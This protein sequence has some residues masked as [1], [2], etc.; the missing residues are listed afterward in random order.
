MTR[1]DESR[2][3]VETGE[4]RPAGIRPPSARQFRIALSFLS[5]AAGGLS[6]GAIGVAWLSIRDTWALP[7]S[8]LGL[9]LLAMTAGFLTGSFVSGHLVT[10]LGMGNTLAFCSVLTALGLL[11]FA[12]APDW[13]ALI[14]IAILSGAGK[15][16]YGASLNIYFANHFDARL[17]NWLHASFGLG[18]ALSPF[19]VQLSSSLEHGWRVTW[20]GFALMQLAF[21]IAF[22]LT[23][24]GWHTSRRTP[25]KSAAPASLRATLRQPAVLLAMLFIFVLTGIESS[26]GNWSYTLFREARGVDGATAAA[27]VGLYWGSFTLGRLAFGMVADRFP[28]DASIRLLLGL[29]LL[30]GLLFSLRDSPVL[31]VAGLMLLAFAQAPVTPLLYA[32]S[33]ARLG[34]GLATHAIGF[35]MSAAGLGF[36]ALPALVGFV[37]DSSSLEIL[38]PFVA[39]SSLVCLLLF[40]RLPRH[41]KARA[42]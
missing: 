12:L 27:W 30:G 41:G 24:R 9:L 16:T 25:A 2:R 23:R 1:S 6:G 18:A 14:V 7:T 15:G 13:T 28:P 8:H 38:G 37:A 33:P 42:A 29:V 20:L 19:A 32:T 21:S 3:K 5:F 10:R 36:S 34:E 11:A 35:Q 17:M 22:C 4:G 39:L 31:S 40:G 26:G